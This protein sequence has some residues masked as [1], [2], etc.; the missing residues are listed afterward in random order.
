MSFSSGS[1]KGKRY[2][3]G[4]HGSSHYQKKG[5]FG[6]MLNIF[7]SGS[8]S[9]GKYNNNQQQYDNQNF[10]TSTRGI[11]CKRCSAIVPAGSK[12]CAQCGEK[13]T[14]EMFCNSCGEKVPQN[15]K[16]CLKCGSK[17]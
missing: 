17:I 12:F 10:N 5:L 4:H 13:V 11:P 9:H 1:S 2:K 3:S 8:S 14:A 15:A 16:F 6:N 7:G